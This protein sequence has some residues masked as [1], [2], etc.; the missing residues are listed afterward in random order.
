[1]NV[2]NIVVMAGSNNVDH[3][4]SSPRHLRRQILV[5]GRDNA[6]LL[7]ETN[8]DIENLLLHLHSWAPEAKIRVVNVLPRESRVRNKVISDINQYISK[9][10]DKHSFV[11]LLSTEKS[12]HLFTDKLGFRKQQY[13]SSNGDDNIH[14]NRLGIIRLANH[15]KYTVHHY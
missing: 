10:Q 6:K 7:D 8:R 9:L 14:L 3:I 2:S 4:L 11:S 13:F 15:L 12:R 1:M 5:N